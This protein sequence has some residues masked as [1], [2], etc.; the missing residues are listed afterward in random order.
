MQFE[1]HVEM[2]F[3]IPATLSV[4]ELSVFE[5]SVFELSGF[6]L[7]VFELSVFELSVFELSVFE[8]SVF[9]LSGFELSG[10]ELSPCLKVSVCLKVSAA[11]VADTFLKPTF[12]AFLCNTSSN[13]IQ[14]F[15]V[16]QV[17]FLTLSFFSCGS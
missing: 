3:I 12:S 15:R 8:L 17:P 9:E 2:S 4:F 11:V 1:V 13:V 6:E 16:S 10:F 7:S 5:L 14:L